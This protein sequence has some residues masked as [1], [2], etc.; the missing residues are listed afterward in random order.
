MIPGHVQFLSKYSPRMAQLSE[1]LHLLTCKGVKFNL[2][3]EHNDAFHT[4]EKDLTSAPV[5]NYYDP[6]K[7]VVLHMDAS[8]K[9]SCAVLLQENKPVYFASKAL[10][11]SQKKYVAIE[12]KAL[13]VSWAV[14]KF[15]H[16]LYGQQFTLETDQMPLE[17]ILNKSLLEASPQ[18]QRLLIKTVPYDMT[19]KYIQRVTNV[20]ADCLSNVPIALD[21]IQLP[22]QQGHGITEQLKC[23]ADNLH[24]IH[25]ETVQHDNLALLKHSIQLGWP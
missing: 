1:D 6:S 9:G 11:A 3:P 18:M 22:I 4:V 14:K 12:L 20:V 2:G 24:Q 21:K 15:H 17:S 7:L 13:A 10:Q 16:Y 5:T 25:Q 23:T 19:V 8:L